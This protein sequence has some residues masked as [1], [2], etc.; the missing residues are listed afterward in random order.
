MLATHSSKF[1]S[2]DSNL[3]RISMLQRAMNEGKQADV[4][5]RTLATHTLVSYDCLYAFIA[6]LG[7]DD[8]F[9]LEAQF[10]CEASLL[11]ELKSI[12]PNSD[13]PLSLAIHA[14]HLVCITGDLQASDSEKMTIYLPLIGIMTKRRILVMGFKRAFPLNDNAE[15]FFDV[16]AQSLV[17]YFQGQMNAP[18]LVALPT[19]NLINKAALE[20]VN[21]SERQ[22]MI[23][24]M[25]AE[26][27]TNR[28]ISRT[29]GFTEAT[30]RYETIK[31]YERLRVKNRA[32][33][34]SRIRELLG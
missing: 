26:G 14:A 4:L 3:L 10:D 2:E 23:A 15:I 32:Q 22:I 21:L 29:L 27:S 31:L 24:K 16:I 19:D 25:I 34:S 18:S 8:K 20:D 7:D 13:H 6:T 30:I 1:S 17:I 33:A 11:K 12:D 5:L 9:Y 28:Q